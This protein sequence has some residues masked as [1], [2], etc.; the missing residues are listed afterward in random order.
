MPIYDY[1][2]K[3]CGAFSAQMPMSAYL[4]DQHCPHC[5]RSAPRA[6]LTTPYFASMDSGKRRA[7]ATNER[8]SHLP[9]TAAGSGRHPP[10]CSCCHGPQRRQ[11]DNPTLTKSFPGNRPWMISH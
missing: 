10:S 7:H 9:A 11:A 4:D 5:G 6:L 2:C 3:D 8:S 1:L